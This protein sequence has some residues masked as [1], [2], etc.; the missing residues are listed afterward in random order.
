[1]ALVATSYIKT[2]A[3]AASRSAD[4]LSFTFNARP[5]AM[6][7]YVRFVESGSISLPSA[8]RIVS[9][10]RTTT[11]HLSLRVAAAGLYGIRHQ[12]LVTRSSILAASPGL[13]QL[14][15]LRGTLSDSGI[16]QAHQTIDGGTETSASASDG[17]V[18]GGAWGHAELWVNS[19]NGA[20]I[21]V[22]K[23]L[24]LSVVRGVQT[25]ATMRRLAGVT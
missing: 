22:I 18:L 3:A 14:V 8:T 4:N 2:A 11:P 23:C 21:G 24:N 13:G 7:I 5:Q 20:G 10:G 6:T 25:L 15:E 16:V 19:A 1:M 12:Y 17:S 9:I